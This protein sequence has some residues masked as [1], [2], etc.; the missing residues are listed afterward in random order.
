MANLLDCRLAPGL[1]PVGH[2]SWNVTPMRR[3]FALSASHHPLHA[4]DPMQQG[5]NS[6]RG[7]V[8]DAYRWGLVPSWSQDPSVGNNLFNAR[9]ETLADKPAFRSA[10]AQRRCVV[11]A[12]G[13][14]EWRL[15]HAD[16][17]R[18]DPRDGKIPY[19]FRRPDDD[20]LLM[21][22]LWEIWRDPRSPDDLD[23]M[24]RTCTIITV[25]AG[26]DVAPVHERMPALISRSDV[27]RWVDPAVRDG[28]AVAPL[29]R[30]A[31]AGTLISYR[32]DRRVGA[33]AN[34]GAALFEPLTS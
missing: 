31:P 8:I 3:V 6:T 16:D 2:P 23:T 22:G 9:A 25:P 14:Y 26:P 19:A 28:S 12:D 10:F 17:P 27:D 33:V 18:E 32:V 7:R 5:T 11:L 4:L 21:A 34:D 15:P 13:F 29:L 1:D 20:L 30:P 24:L